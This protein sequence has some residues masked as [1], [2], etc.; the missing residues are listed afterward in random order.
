MKRRGRLNREKEAEVS[1]GRKDSRG[2]ELRRDAWKEMSANEK[3]AC[4]KWMAKKK[5]AKMGA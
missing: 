4:V 5:D 1:K 2:D 3:S